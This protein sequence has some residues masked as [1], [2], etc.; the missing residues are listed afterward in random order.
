VSLT[1]GI[2]EEY[3]LVD[4][5]S[6]SLVPRASEVLAAG[7]DIAVLAAE[8]NRCQIEIATGVWDDLAG[9][10][11]EI[12]DLRAAVAKAGASSGTRPTALASHPFSSWDD[13][14]VNTDKARYVRLEETY[15]QIAWQQAICGCHV[16]VGI[17]DRD[18][19]IAVMDRV[20][21]WLP[22]LLAL[23][24]N[25]PYWQGKDTGY[26]SYRSIVWQPWPTAA[27]PPRLDT[28]RRYEAMVAE[29]TAVEAIEN[30][31]SLYWYARPSEAYETL[32]F[33]VCDVCLHARDAVTL[34]GLIRALVVVCAGEATAGRAY[35]DPPP[36]ILESAMWRAARYG[37]DNTLVDPTRRALV[38]A[39][40]A[41]GQFV[42][43]VRPGLEAAGDTERVVDGVKAILRDGN[44]GGAAAGRHRRRRYGER[45]DLPDPRL[46]TDRASGGRGLA[47]FAVPT[48]RPRP[49]AQGSHRR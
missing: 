24:A 43:H 5:G 35:D 13:Q 30:P 19:R 36:P 31:H 9:A 14:E 39:A 10:E 20:R 22:V 27:M 4:T 42:D 7:S 47:L 11:R 2:E 34:A 17:E 21:P 15:R 18:L 29:L 25:S 16:H 1:F 12:D 48:G 49:A 33:R 8:L 44:G 23:S 28:Y 32:E 45:D 6:G 38:P 46:L 26:A 40:A 3:L 41:V 37:M